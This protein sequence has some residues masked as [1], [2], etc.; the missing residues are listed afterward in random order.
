MRAS[1]LAGAIFITFSNPGWGEQATAPARP[2]G[3]PE[4]VSFESAPRPLGKLQER[5]ARERG[6]DPKP[7]PG[8]RLEGYL[9]KP[10]GTGPFPAVVVMAGCAG[11]TLYVRETLPELLK[12]WGYVALAV[13][14]LAT[15]NVK[16][17]CVK[18]HASV[19]RLAD[20]YGGLFYLAGLPYVD[21]DHVAVMGVSIGGK[22]AMVLADRDFEGTVANPDKLMFKAGVALYPTCTVSNEEPRFPILIMIGQMD[23]M[24]HVSDCEAL[25]A[26]RA[27]NA[28]PT[29][30]VVYPG[31]HHG[32]VERDWSG[33]REAYGAR[34]EYNE[35][36]AEDALRRTRRFL[37]NN[38]GGG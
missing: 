13:D 10:Q 11:Q 17:D 25:A 19:D 12:S 37:A 29:E 30:L 9:A 32:F 38:L 23:R 20:A 2:D 5:R 14:S 7:T 1:V 34:F 8:V 4:K 24:T 6:E 28:I 3:A 18:D 26:R 36:A 22:I 35:E 16:P 31:T 27:G 15:R 33:G 21:R